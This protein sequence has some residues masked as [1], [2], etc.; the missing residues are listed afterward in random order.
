MHRNAEGRDG[1]PV[2]RGTGSEM[3]MGIAI[4]H[5]RPADPRVGKYCRGALVPLELRGRE[6]N[7]RSG[8][9]EA[10]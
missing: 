3:L 7:C 4:E 5:R 10:A 2:D 1:A 6:S 8:T 9:D